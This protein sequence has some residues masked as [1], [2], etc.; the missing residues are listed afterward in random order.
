VARIDALGERRSVLRHPF[1]RRWS[2]GELTASELA[3]YAAEYR[4][5]LLARAALAELAADR[6]RASQERE[7]VLL[8]EA[9]ARVCGATPTPPSAATAQCALAWLAAED[10][11]ERLAV[12]YALES[13]EPSIARAQLRG[14]LDHYGF[15]GSAATEYFVVRAER[16]A[17]HAA[18]ARALLLAHARADSRAR[19]AGRAE[20][21]LAGSWRLLD[22]VGR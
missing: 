13:A 10:R 15:K 7:H 22:G 3:R 11:L 6:E 2:A 14:L 16:G 18:A 1:L 20:A 19:L 9:F 4:W 8:W 21:A 5:P 12:L 17:E